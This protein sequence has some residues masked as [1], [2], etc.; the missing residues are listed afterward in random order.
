MSKF[1]IKE[2][3]N[4]DLYRYGEGISF[5]TRLKHLRN[6]GF[7]Y[8]YVFRKVQYYKNRKLLYM[9]YRFLLRRYAFKY[10]YDISFKTKIGKGFNINHW[11]SVVINP[12]TIIGDNVNIT[13]GVLL[14]KSNRGKRKGYPVIGN[15]VWIGAH[16]AIIGNVKIGDNV[17]VA[18]NSY[19]NID[20][21]SN[22][23]VFGN[24]A[25]IKS[26]EEAV[27]DYIKHTV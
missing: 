6:P 9:F 25:V 16:A 23:I 10:G 26:S 13:T 27:L 2:I 18:P 21:P 15:K 17:L 7:K 24:P 12:H 3:I 1:N 11:G 22:S 5:K 20:V 8:M 4:S 19:V 14:G